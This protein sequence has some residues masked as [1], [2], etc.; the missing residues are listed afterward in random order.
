MLEFFIFAAG[1]IVGWFFTVLAN[2]HAIKESSECMDQANKEKAAATELHR[3]TMVK[4]HEIGIL[5]NEAKVSEIPLSEE[6]VLKIAALVY[7]KD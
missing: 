4:A 6:G 5:L 1:I 3:D 2:A 7:N